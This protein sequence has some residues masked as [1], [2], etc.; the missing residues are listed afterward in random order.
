EALSRP[1]IFSKHIT[2]SSAWKCNLDIGNDFSIP[3]CAYIK[4]KSFKPAQSW[5][6]VYANDPN[7]EFKQ[8]STFHL[9]DDDE[10]EI[11]VNDTI[12]AYYYGS[13]LVPVSEESEKYKC[14]KC[15]KVLGFTSK[16]NVVS[17]AFSAFVNALFETNLVAIVRRVYAGSNAPRIGCLKPHIKYKYEC[18]I[19]NE[20]PFHEDMMACQFNSL[21]VGGISAAK[22]FKPSDVQLEAV[23]NLIDSMT[24][25]N[26]DGEHNVFNSKNKPN[27]YLQK[28]YQCFEERVND[29]TKPIP[30]VPSSLM[31]KLGVTFFENK[32][33]MQRIKDNF[34][35]KEL[36]QEKTK[37]TG[38]KLFGK[39]NNSDTYMKASQKDV[40]ST[41]SEQVSDDMPKEDFKQ[42]FLAGKYFED[43][44]KGK[45]SEENAGKNESGSQ[46][47]VASEEIKVE[48][49]A[50]D[51]LDEM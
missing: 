37:E 19:Y 7:A 24:F 26:K 35:L 49:S 20:L 29:P 16:D 51:L 5:K 31:N 21:P 45:T 22:K 23:D 2:K 1:N 40:I 11:D 33:A 10:T 28:F 32:E 30:D 41:S 36:K 46:K 13:T 50:D 9:N 8:S 43:K 38:E 3:I 44:R 17:V 47:S 12:S 25:S 48:N 15:F 39:S 42:L 14:E 27:P 4:M 6:K 34:E 18:M